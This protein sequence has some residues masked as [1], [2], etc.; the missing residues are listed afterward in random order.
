[1][2]PRNLIGAVLIVLS[3]AAMLNPRAAAARRRFMPGNA[4]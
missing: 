1:M 4:G 3:A 2:P